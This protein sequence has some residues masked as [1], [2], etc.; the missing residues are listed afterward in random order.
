MVT[1]EPSGAVAGADV[2]RRHGRDGEHH[3]PQ[4]EERGGE[5]LGYGSAHPAGEPQ[6]GGAGGG[7]SPEQPV[8]HPSP[9]PRRLAGGEAPH[10]H[11][12]RG[13]Q[14]E[15][16]HRV[17]AVGRRPAADGHESG[18]E[19]GGQAHEHRRR[20]ARRH[21]VPGPDVVVEPHQQ[22]RRQRQP[23]AEEQGR[24]V[25]G[26]QVAQRA[27]SQE[28]EAHQE[29]GGADRRPKGRHRRQPGAP[30]RLAQDHAVCPRRG[31]LLYE[32]SIRAL[33]TRA[34]PKEPGRRRR[35]ASPGR[36]R[37]RRPGARPPR[38]GAGTPRSLP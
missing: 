24:S 32:P 28:V 17:D 18:H 20:E 11:R 33:S 12:Q 19:L 34:S 10:E 22:E 35:Q 14:D 4:M 16:A 2:A 29:G 5:D 38:S 31:A 27:R 25:L 23:A 9:S 26:R 30:E 13:A 3:D 15:G 8:A 36:G 6:A 37:A 1:A 21:R 7:L